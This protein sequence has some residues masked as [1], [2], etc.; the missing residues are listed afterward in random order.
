MTR[1]VI[2]ARYSTERQTDASIQDQF[3]NCEAHCEREGWTIVDRY[4]DEA[5]SGR[6]ADRP[7]YQR[8]L[9]D[10]ETGR[11]DILVVD[12]L[13]RLS[14]CCRAFLAQRPRSS[15]CFAGWSGRCAAR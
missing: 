13:S 8:M 4:G 6:K 3:R 11:F 10:A 1:A 14:R 15:E 2:Y 9:A 12:D 5:M 7:G